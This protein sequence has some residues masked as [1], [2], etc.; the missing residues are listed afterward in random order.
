MKRCVVVGRPNVGK[1]LLVLRLA[2]HL[3]VK[4]VEVA[5]CEPHGRRESKTYPLDAAIRELVGQNPH[6]TRCLQSIVVAVPAAKG[7]RVVEIVDTTGLVDYIHENPQVRKA[8]AQ[9][10]EVLRPA[11]LIIHV[12]DAAETGRDGRADPPVGTIDRQLADFAGSRGGYFIVANK[13]DLPGASHGLARLQ[14]LFS[15][16]TVLPVSAAAKTGLQEVKRHVLRN[17]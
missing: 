1:T 13:M 10:L 9:T 3:K 16:Y 6:Q 2:E 7:R 4:T 8:M 14:R 5:F 15:A 11:D 17:L 12:I